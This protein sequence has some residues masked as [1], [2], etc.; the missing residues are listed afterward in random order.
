MNTDERVKELEENQGPLTWANML[1]LLR[2][3]SAEKSRADEL[4]EVYAQ[5]WYSNMRASEEM[6]MASERRAK[7]AESD[8]AKA[9]TELASSDCRK[10]GSAEWGTLVSERDRLKTELGEA[11]GQVAAILAAALRLRMCV[12]PYVSP[13][14]KEQIE[15]R[16]AADG[17]DRFNILPSAA[18]HAHDNAVRAEVWEEAARGVRRQTNDIELARIFENKAA[19]LRG[20]R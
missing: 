7:Q 10:C 15:L 1:F 11:R 18:A 13:V 3:L 5:D 2:V 4:A 16:E 12:W 6:H 14:G 19:A 9:R 17:V 20:Q 8:L